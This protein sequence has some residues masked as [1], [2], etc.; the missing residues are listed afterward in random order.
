MKWIRVFDA[1]PTEIP[2]KHFGSISRD[3]IIYDESCGVC[4]N[5]N[6]YKGEFVLIENGGE[7]ITKFNK[8]THWMYNPPPPE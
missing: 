8:V 7:Y 5:I 4:G 1:L 6:Y 2:S 3:L